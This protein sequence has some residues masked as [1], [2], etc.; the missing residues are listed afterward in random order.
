MAN[1]PQIVYPQNP[2]TSKTVLVNIVGAGITWLA[3]KYG[4][5]SVL[6]PEMQ[7]QAALAVAMAIMSGANL[8]VR[9]YFTGA[10]LSFDAPLSQTP[11]Q[12]LPSGSAVVVATSPLSSAAPASVTPIRAGDQVVSIERQTLVGADAPAPTVMVTTTPA[13]PPPSR[14]R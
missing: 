2:I 11:A 10:P 8:V 9:K 4:L 6:T 14:R 5:G 12:P 1:E 3:V 7:N 13:P